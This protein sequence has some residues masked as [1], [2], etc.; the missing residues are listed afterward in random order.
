MGSSDQSR[1]RAAAYTPLRP[2]GRRSACDAPLVLL[3]SS[4]R[5]IRAIVRAR[6]DLSAIAARPLPS[7]GPTQ[8]KAGRRRVNLS[9][10]HAPRIARWTHTK[11]SDELKANRIAFGVMAGSVL[12]E[13][14][15]RPGTVSSARSQ[16]G[17]RATR[18]E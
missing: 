6:S 7:E 5:P 16:P 18:D 14:S 4:R 10:Y 11:Q 2:N 9:E 3:C 17:D 8:R 12:D 1:S 13:K 15:G